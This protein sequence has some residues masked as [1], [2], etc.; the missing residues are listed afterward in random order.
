MVKRDR[1][2]IRRSVIPEPLEQLELREAQQALAGGEAVCVVLAVECRERA[3]GGKPGVLH[4][5][6]EVPE[7][8]GVK[9]RLAGSAE[10]CGSRSA[11]S[12]TVS[13][14]GMSARDT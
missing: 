3:L 4:P 13:S 8:V 5:L 1:R 6:D 9:P 7:P 10:P 11:R 14:G 2:R 12:R